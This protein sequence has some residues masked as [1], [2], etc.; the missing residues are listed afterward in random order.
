VIDAAGG[1]AGEKRFFLSRELKAIIAGAK[2]KL[3]RQPSH[4]N[5]GLFPLRPARKAMW[6]RSCSIQLMMTNRLRWL[7]IDSRH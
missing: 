1:V 4:G 7:R 2:T 3:A 5:S 6:M